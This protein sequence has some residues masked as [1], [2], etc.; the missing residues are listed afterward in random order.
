MCN[1][2]ITKDP[3]TPQ[4]NVSLHYLVKCQV[5]AYQKK[6]CHFWATLYAVVEL[7]AYCGVDVW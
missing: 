3:T 2:I 6:L 5:K 1:N 4:I 7:V